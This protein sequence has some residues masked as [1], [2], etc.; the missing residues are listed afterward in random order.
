MTDPGFLFVAL[1]V[2]FSSVNG[3]LGVRPDAFFRESAPQ[4]VLD[5]VT[6]GRPVAS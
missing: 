4:P 3:A 1:R 5:A 2:A 6:F